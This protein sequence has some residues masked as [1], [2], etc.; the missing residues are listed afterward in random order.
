MK[1]LIVLLAVLIARPG[2]PAFAAS[3]DIDAGRQKA[4][5]CTGCHGQ[6]GISTVKGVPT[7]AG[8]QDQFLQWQLVFFRSGRRA[9]AAMTAIVA[10]L[11]DED[12][13]DLG[14]YYA[15]L[16]R[17]TAPAGGPADAAL[18]A[19]GQQIVAEYHCAN[20][21]T[22]T[23]RGERAAA[24]IADQRED[25]LVKALSDYRSAARPSVGVAAMTE[26]ATGLN[27]DEIAAIAHYLANYQLAGP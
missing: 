23:F 7:L 13:R 24:A 22:E 19:R 27:D 21:H 4:M 12:I 9:N 26:A 18:L 14:A 10:N 1:A 17:N 11:T 3:G 25:Y 15:S 5:I 2:S 6:T 8:Q 20:C 16:P